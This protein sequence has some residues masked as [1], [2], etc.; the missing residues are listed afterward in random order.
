MTRR[1]VVSWSASLLGLFVSR[2]AVAKRSKLTDDI[3]IAADWIAQALNSSGYKA[4]F[5]PASIGEI[6]RFLETQTENGKA[7]AGGLLSADL[8][9]KLFALGSYCGEVL[10]RD[11]G[12]EWFAEDSDPQGEINATL[13]LTNGAI[14]WPIQRVMK[15]FRSADD[16][17][18]IWADGLRTEHI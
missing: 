16:S 13:K 12:G 5:T 1:G 6:E 14:G 4:D 18:I 11:V 9:S 2:R 3:L 10:R 7:T 17:L 8:G 15:R